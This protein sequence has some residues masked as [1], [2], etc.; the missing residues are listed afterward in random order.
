MGYW[1]LFLIAFLLTVIASLYRRMLPKVA[2]EFSNDGRFCMFENGVR[3]Y[4][5]D[6]NNY[7]DH[8]DSISFRLDHIQDQNGSYLPMDRR[9]LQRESGNGPMPLSPESPKYAFLAQL[10]ERSP[11]TAIEIMTISDVASGYQPDPIKLPRGRYTLSVSLNPRAGRPH[12]ARF[13][14]W[15]DPSNQLRIAKESLPQRKFLGSNRL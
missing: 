7:G 10:D 5:V 4:R 9:G 12:K 2:I 8:Q 6:L 11:D 1:Q 14:V 13:A 15:V 3:K